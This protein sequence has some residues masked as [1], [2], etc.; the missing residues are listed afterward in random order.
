[1]LLMQTR[2]LLN[3]KSVDILIKKR[4]KVSWMGKLVNGE[5]FSLSLFQALRCCLQEKT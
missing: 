5:L 1:M 3:S 4:N 2:F